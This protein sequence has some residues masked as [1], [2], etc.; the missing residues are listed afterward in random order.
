M[1]TARIAVIALFC[2]AVA[3]PAFAQVDWSGPELGVELGGAVG[4]DSGKGTCDPILPCAGTIKYGFDPSGP[5]GGVHA[6]YNFQFNQFVVGGEADIEGADLNSSQT[7]PAF[8]T[9]YRF[10]MHNYW[11]ASVR[12]RLGYA[13]SHYLLYG[14]GGVAFGDVDQNGFC[15]GCLMGGGFE[16]WNTTRI[17]WTAGAGIDYAMSSNWS[18]GLEYRYTDLG[19]ANFACLAC[20]DTDHNHFD[21]NSFWLRI[22]YRFAP[23]PPPPAPIP[24]VAPAPPP[25]MMARTFLVFFDF[26]RYF[27]TPDAG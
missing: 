2:L 24:V 23:P 3:P 6:G 8:G 1:R 26:D 19:S 10:G 11:D 7:Q 14:T 27:L 13:F 16:T 15:A 22:T 17:G 5:L 20:N 12:A 18:A 9:V 4:H 25:P 21:S